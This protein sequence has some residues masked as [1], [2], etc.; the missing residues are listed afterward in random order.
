MP[1]TT[2]I[3]HLFDL[4][5]DRIGE[6]IDAVLAGG[7]M[8][9]LEYVNQ[10]D[11]CTWLLRSETGDEYELSRASGPYMTLPGLVPLGN[12][13]LTRVRGYAGQRDSLK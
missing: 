5:A 6:P 7:Q 12:A 3:H 11:G 1:I 2:H 4:P 9:R 13:Q 10:I 8:R